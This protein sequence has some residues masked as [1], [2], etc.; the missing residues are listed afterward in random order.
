M[1]KKIE[2]YNGKEITRSV[3]KR[4]NLID[5]K[6]IKE[7]INVFSMESVKTLKS[8]CKAHQS[9]P[10]EEYIILGEDW[11]IIYTKIFATEIDIK[12]WVA[13][14]NVEN[15][16]TQTME[17]YSSLKQL[18]LENKDCDFY[19]MLRHSTSYPFYKKFL[20]EGHIE[21]SMD[22]I[23]FD[24][25]SP[26]LTKIKEKILTEYNSIEEYLSDPNRELYKESHLEDY[27]YHEVSFNVTNTFQNKYKKSGR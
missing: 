2:Y 23:D 4:I 7:G 1:R 8:L 22:V 12:D 19:C 18:F 3:L 6:R 21:E 14:S 15:K 11:Y 10:E 20:D 13:I 26:E 27:I 25:Y 5:I 24:D 16:L 9:D 17:M